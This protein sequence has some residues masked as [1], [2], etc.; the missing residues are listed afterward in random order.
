[1][2]TTYGFCWDEGCNW[3]E[4]RSVPFIKSFHF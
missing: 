4:P 2:L 3:M 1:M